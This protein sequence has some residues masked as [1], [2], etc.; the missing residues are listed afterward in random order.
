MAA[1]EK[2]FD[3]GFAQ[4]QLDFSSDLAQVNNI[5]MHAAVGHNVIP[6]GLVFTE[7]NVG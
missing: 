5:L 2:P 6:D 1:S 7:A 3:Y 4:G